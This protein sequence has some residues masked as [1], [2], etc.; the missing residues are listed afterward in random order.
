MIKFCFTIIWQKCHKFCED[1][2]SIV[3]FEP[4]YEK[5]AYDMT[6]TTY[7]YDAIS[8]YSLFALG[9]T[10]NEWRKMNI[11]VKEYDFEFKKN[12][13]YWVIEFLIEIWDKFPTFC[14]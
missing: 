2:I 12:P 6:S 5:G 11:I 13:K 8:V 4:V 14:H 1:Q 10:F 9:L 3:T 7:I